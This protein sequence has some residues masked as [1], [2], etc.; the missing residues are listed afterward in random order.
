MSAIIV[1]I[2][3]SM[4]CVLNGEPIDKQPN[5]AYDRWMF[6]PSSD[7]AGLKVGDYR[8]RLALHSELGRFLRAGSFSIGS[9]LKLMKRLI[10]LHELMRGPQSAKGHA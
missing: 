8:H 5:P 2:D 4:P 3:S 9:N 6:E 10:R 1:S 7:C